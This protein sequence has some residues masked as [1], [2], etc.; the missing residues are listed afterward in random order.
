MT[1]RKFSGGGGTSTTG[2]PLSAKGEEKLSRLVDAMAEEAAA[3]SD[4]ELDEEVRAEGE[5]PTAVAQRMRSA[6]DQL[7]K[8]KPSKS[9]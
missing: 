4:A 6:V 1:R 7:L 9:R 5:E 3:Q 2:L 8:S